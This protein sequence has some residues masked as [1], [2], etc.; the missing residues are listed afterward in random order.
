MHKNDINLFLNWWNK[1]LLENIWV[2]F[3]KK[4][5]FLVLLKKMKDRINQIEGT[6]ILI[7]FLCINKK[8]V[9]I[10]DEA[11]LYF[12]KKAPPPKKNK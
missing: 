10:H 8:K 9:L 5:V 2:L 3:E 12:E 4:P 7:N 11:Y 6:N 1:G